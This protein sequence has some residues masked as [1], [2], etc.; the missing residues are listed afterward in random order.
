MGKEDVQSLKDNDEITWELSEKKLTAM[1]KREELVEH[2]EE[3]KSDHSM[4]D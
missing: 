1:K 3:Y 4:Q 2:F